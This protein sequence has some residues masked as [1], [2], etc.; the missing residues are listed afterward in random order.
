MSDGSDVCLPFVDTK[1]DVLLLDFLTY[2]T[3]RTLLRLRFCFSNS[4]HQQRSIH[5]T[6]TFYL[7]AL[8]FDILHHTNKQ[9]VVPERCDIRCTNV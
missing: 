8:L 3:T 7:T 4:T 5:E 6:G 9:H 2:T 1:V